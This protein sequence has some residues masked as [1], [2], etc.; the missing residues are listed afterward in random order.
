[1]KLILNEH[2]KPIAFYEVT[3]V[4]RKDMDG[5]SHIF[6]YGLNRKTFIRIPNEAADIMMNYFLWNNEFRV[7]ADCFEKWQDNYN[8]WLEIEKDRKE[9]EK[10]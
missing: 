5:Q 10:W 6:F 3:E 2:G 7:E 8:E 1:M 4:I 9:A